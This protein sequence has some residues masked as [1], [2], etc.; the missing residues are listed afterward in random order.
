MVVQSPVKHIPYAPWRRHTPL[1]F[2]ALMQPSIKH[3]GVTLPFLLFD[4]GFP[5]PPLLSIASNKKKNVYIKLL[6]MG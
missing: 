6:K 4:H 3:V 2:T 5:H 1:H